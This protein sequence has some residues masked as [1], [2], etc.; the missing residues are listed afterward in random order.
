[1]THNDIE[2][3]AMA[4]KMLDANMLKHYTVGMLGRE[5]GMSDTKL[6]WAFRQLYGQSVYAYQLNRRLCHAYGL[7]SEGRYNMKEIARLTGFKQITHFRARFKKQFG[8]TPG[9]VVK[10]R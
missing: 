7:L 1:M 3:V 5:I 4:K 2:L 9:S 8:I 6:K 10:Y